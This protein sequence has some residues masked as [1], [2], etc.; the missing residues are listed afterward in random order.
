MFRH[1]L[2]TLF[3]FFAFTQNQMAQSETNYFQQEVNTVLKVELDDNKHSLTGAAFIEYT[4]NSPEN[5]DTIYF[6]LWAN[7]YMSKSSAFAKQ[8]IDQG[9]LDFYFTDESNMGG[10]DSLEF[11]IGGRK[12]TWN[13]TKEHKDIAFLIPE[14]SVS[15]GK[16]INITIPF[17]VKIP[18]PFSRFGH[19]GQG[20]QITQWFPKPAVYDNNGWHPMPYLN[21]GEF[22]SEFGDYDVTLTVP[23]N[24]YV[25]AT[26][27]LVT[28]S[29]LNRI[30]DRIKYTQSLSD[31]TIVTDDFPVSDTILKTIRFI[32]EDVHDFAWFADKRFLIKEKPITLKDEAV[33]KGQIFYLPSGKRLWDKGLDYLERGVQFYSDLVGPYP[34]PKVAAVQ[35]ALK[36]GGGMEYP[37]V[38][39]ISEGGTAESLDHVIIHEVGHNWFYGILASNERRYGWM[40]EGINSYYDQR[41]TRTYYPKDT[42]YG[43]VPESIKKLLIKDWFALYHNMAHKRAIAQ[44]S[45]LHSEDYSMYNYFLSLYQ[46]PPMAF[47]YLANYLGVDRFDQIMQSYYEKYKFKHP[48]PADLEDHFQKSTNMDLDW[49]FKGMLGDIAVFDYSL[50]S[51]KKTTDGFSL[52]IENNSEYRIPFE[53]TGLKDGNPVYSE[54]IDGFKEDTILVI[55]ESANDHFVLDYNQYYSEMS[56]TDNM[57]PTNWKQLFSRRP[58]SFK[59]FN[60]IDDP[61]KSQV[62]WLPSIGWN[63]S[64]GIMAGLM[65]FNTSIPK[66]NLEYILHPGYAFGS[67]GEDWLVGQGK[68]SFNWY[69]NASLR[70]IKLFLSGKSFHFDLPNREGIRYVNFKLGGN[71]RF[72]ESLRDKKYTDLNITFHNI[73]NER[74]V[75]DPI[76]IEDTYSTAITIDLE[77]KDQNVLLPL[78]WKLNVELADFENVYFNENERYLKASASFSTH[79]LYRKNKKIDVR[80]YAAGMLF[81]SK[82]KS[83]NTRPGTMGLIGYAVNDYLY[84]DYFFDRG[85]Q[86][87]VWSRQ[88]N[89]NGGGFKTAV[90]NAYNL[91]QSNRYVAAMNIKADLPFDI[92]VLST[93]KPFF[94]IGTYAYLPTLSDDYQNKILYSGGFMIDSYDGLFNIYLP[95]IN[96]EEIENIYKEDGKFLN[97][98]SFSINLKLLDFTQL[99]EREDLLFGQ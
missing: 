12:A 13:F 56:T 39:V 41:Y 92:P 23:A 97:R 60:I 27:E 37:M 64:D 93:I 77:R 99:L 51:A 54:W 95:L 25:V 11:Y 36:A 3:F 88:I 15:P 67:N 78:N 1:H 47:N 55:Q 68:L 22:Y 90:S 5:L 26:G 29:E 58:H 61:L 50:N 76:D 52:R 8:M 49:F 79:F 83:T 40:D 6:H 80:L 91:G 35:G 30:K 59:L 72:N 75:F 98:I 66:Q 70:N 21:M 32:A 63:K 84:E 42:L 57:I 45:D 44:P 46:N 17:T 94:D 86:E 33:V 43:T 62:K 48:Q 65:L 24:Y 74:Y 82:P 34:Y 38:T 10:Y 7:A 71:L 20:Y 28:S 89:M 73:F 16:T 31:E 19:D 18:G 14:K 53:L 4:N 96:S 85:T 87:G 2:F 9:D 81:H 69:R